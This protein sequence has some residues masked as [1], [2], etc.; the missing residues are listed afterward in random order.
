MLTRFITKK[1]TTSLSKKT[2]SVAQKRALTKAIK[3]SADARRNKKLVNL[4]AKIA[5]NKKA[6]SVLKRNTKTVY[7]LQ[8]AKGEGP[9]MG[10]NLRHY[11]NMPVT[12]KRGYKVAP[13]SDYNR[14]RAALLKKLAPKGTPFEEI[15][16]SKKDKFAFSSVKQANKYFS[17][18]EQKYLST[19]GFS[20][21]TIR[22]ATV[23]GATK[24]QVSYNLNPAIKRIEKENLKLAKKYERL[25]KKPNK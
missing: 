18:E 5:N 10:K 25:A 22:N 9:L 23:V 7:R 12:V 21:Q 19:K 14:R 15:K 16:F 4:G 17:K 3:A 6:L 11:A 20:L 24:T 13:V 2:M 8:N 1:L